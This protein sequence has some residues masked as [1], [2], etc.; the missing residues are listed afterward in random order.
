[1]RGMLLGCGVLSSVV[2]VVMD[3]LSSWRYEGYSYTDQA[4]SELNATGV[5]TRKLFLSMAMPYNALLSAFSAGIWVAAGRRA[6][7]TASMLFL[8]AVVGMVTPLYFPMDRR[9]AERTYRGSMHPPMT[10][11]G[12]LFILLAMGFGANLF[13]PR[14]RTYSYATIVI[15]MVFGGLTAPY[16]PR[17][18][19][20]RSTPWMGVL[21][22]INI[23][24]YLIWVAAL[25]VSFRRSDEVVSGREVE[26]AGAVPRL[27]ERRREENRWLAY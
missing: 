17:L 24:A 10:A 14:F 23:Y 12:S 9:G 18:A 3:G 11:L 5:P 19:A 27:A 20:G 16:A 21:E 15:L 22:R 4:V 7:F 6:R 25:A 13:G 1:M 8:S 26:A 2:Y